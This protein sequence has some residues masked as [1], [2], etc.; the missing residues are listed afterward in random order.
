MV[1]RE[2]INGTLGTLA[3]CVVTSAQS[4]ISG[5]TLVWT[6]R[7]PQNVTWR[8]YAGVN[9]NDVKYGIFTGD[10]VSSNY[11]AIMGC[12][13][14]YDLRLVV[15]DQSN[16]VGYD[17]NILNI[18]ADGQSLGGGV[19]SSRARMEPF[20]TMLSLAQTPY[21][22][23]EALVIALREALGIGG[24]ITYRLTNC[25]APQAPTSA[26]TGTTVV[27][28]L[29]FPEGFTVINPE[30]DVI[31]RNNGI[32]INSNYSAGQSNTG[33]VSFIMP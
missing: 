6:L 16:V 21:D 20:D 14:Q 5:A 27:V 24:S 7:D 12:H 3:Q 30:N 13:N 25:T 28:E 26:V 10:G 18:T 9:R 19:K 17:S 23:R 8:F 15:V 31:V 4:V 1:E 11:E 32:I 22:T 29:E 33:T 2:E